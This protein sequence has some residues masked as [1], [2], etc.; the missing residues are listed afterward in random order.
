M[1]IAIE[2]GS[3]RRGGGEVRCWSGQMRT[4]GSEDNVYVVVKVQVGQPCTNVWNLP[5]DTQ[6][7]LY[8]HVAVVVAVAVLNLG[9]NVFLQ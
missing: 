9:D 2:L 7:R 6:C 3:R 5:V 8:G 1:L 4:L